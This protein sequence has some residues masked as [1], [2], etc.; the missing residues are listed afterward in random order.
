[1]SSDRKSSTDNSNLEIRKRSYISAALRKNNFSMNTSEFKDLEKVL[2]GNLKEKKGSIFSTWKQYYFEFE[3][4]ALF[5]F[6]N[7]GDTSPAEVIAIKES[8]IV[9]FDTVTGKKYT[10]AIFQKD[11]SQ[12]IF[13]ADSQTEK[14]KWMRA[15]EG[16]GN[17][18]TS[19]K[20]ILESINDGGI[21]TDEK[22]N[23]VSANE[24]ACKLFGWTKEELIGKNC[25][26]LMPKGIAALHD[27]F[28]KKYLSTGQKSLIGVPRKMIV[29][30]K[31]DTTF[32]ITIS[33]GEVPPEQDSLVRFIAILRNEDEP[34]TQ[35]EEKESLTPTTETK[36]KDPVV[37]LDFTKIQMDGKLTDFMTA[38]KESMNQSFGSLKQTIKTLTQQ[39]E[40]MKRDIAYLN[41]Q[42]QKEKEKIRDLEEELFFYRN[43]QDNLLVKVLKNEV[44][45]QAFLEF[46]VQEKCDELVHF[47]TDSEAFKKGNDNITE[48]AKNLFAKYLSKSAERPIKVTKEI[49]EFI[50]QNLE[51]PTRNLFVSVQKEV[52]DQ[53]KLRFKKFEST[54]MGKA[55]LKNIQ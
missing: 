52:L 9:D 30:H 10:F 3:K 50:E 24:K 40:I 18:S 14:E 36:F 11:G 54:G 16:T 38:I 33:L 39:E 37:A 34:H 42:I 49:V 43:S 2:C 17:K 27:G 5:V 20:S 41:E 13:M 26:V 4:D 44:G 51:N 15:L 1:M 28:I 12:R 23:I 35:D 7:Q 21:S 29:K 6:K 25:T 46:T 32:P 31:N 53:M 45:Y 8:Q 19:G 22:G 48:G 47:W 55:V